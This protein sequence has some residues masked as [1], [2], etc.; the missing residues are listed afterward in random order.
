MLARHLGGKVVK[1][2]KREVGGYEVRL[3]EVGEADSIFA[4]F[5]REFPVFH[6]HAEMFQVPPEGSLLVMGDPC[7]IQAFGWGNIRG[8]IFHLEITS[9]D[10]ARWANAYPKELEAVGKTRDRVVEECREREPE[11]RRLASLLI[12]N[13]LVMGSSP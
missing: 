10:A 5:P 12:D 7:P 2:P 13:F 6:W 8:V 11:M 1:S 3:T 4:G 9:D